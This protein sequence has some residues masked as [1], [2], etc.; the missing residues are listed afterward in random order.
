MCSFHGTEV[1]S[2]KLKKI[3]TWMKHKETHGEDQCSINASPFFEV[4]KCYSF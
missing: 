3:L 2:L 1:D 4:K